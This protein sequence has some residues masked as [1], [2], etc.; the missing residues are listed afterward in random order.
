MIQLGEW[1]SLATH[2]PLLTWLPQTFFFWYV[3]E[4]IVES[5][6]QASGGMDRIMS[7]T[8]NLYVEALNPM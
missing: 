3:C 4:R 2:L 6:C 7:P 5:V 8:P 1:V